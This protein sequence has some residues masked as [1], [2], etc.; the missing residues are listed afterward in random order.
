MSDLHNGGHDERVRPDLAPI[1]VLDF[2]RVSLTA[3]L[4][5]SWSADDEERIHKRCSRWE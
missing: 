1:E 4:I 5:F 2:I 3:A